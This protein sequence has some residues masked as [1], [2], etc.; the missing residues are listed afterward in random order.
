MESFIIRAYAIWSLIWLVMLIV[1]W[2]RG[3]RAMRLLGYFGVWFAGAAI[4][5]AARV[6]LT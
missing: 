5:A 1:E 4:L 2:R 6:L 3:R